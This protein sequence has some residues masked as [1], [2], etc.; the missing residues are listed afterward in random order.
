M[1]SIATTD[2]IDLTGKLNADGT[3]N[4]TAT[5]R[6]MEYCSFWLFTYWV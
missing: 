2:I 1:M 3:L 4:W 5:C 6:R